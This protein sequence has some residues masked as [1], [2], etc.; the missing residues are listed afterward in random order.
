MFLKE[1]RLPHLSPTFF[2]ITER[3]SE[4]G[5]ATYICEEISLQGVLSQTRRH[6]SEQTGL[7]LKLETI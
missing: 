4:R 6:V 7:S 2:L 1:R 5:S 3:M